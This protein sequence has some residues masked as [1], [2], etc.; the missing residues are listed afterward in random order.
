MQND[1]K[2]IFIWPRGNFSARE[3]RIIMRAFF[4]K[5]RKINDSNKYVVMISTNRKNKVQIQSL[6]V[7]FY[8]VNFIVL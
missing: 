3:A 7:M 4:V 8:L 6:V 1:I 2:Y 5:Y